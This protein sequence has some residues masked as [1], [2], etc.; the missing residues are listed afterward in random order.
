M[1]LAVAATGPCFSDAPRNSAQR[2]GGR[3]QFCPLSEVP[4]EP[5]YVQLTLFVSHI[6]ALLLYDHHVSRDGGDTSGCT[7]L[8][9]PAGIRCF[10]DHH[11]T[12]V[13]GLPSFVR[14]CRP[15]EPTP[16]LAWVPPRCE[17]LST[18]LAQTEMNAP[19]AAKSVPPHSIAGIYSSGIKP[20]MRKTLQMVL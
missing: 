9:T 3:D 18:D 6:S 12:P 4:Q 14:A 7:T 2:R 5:K 8:E 1:W 17:K 16:G 20:H 15:S 19:F 10:V 13:S 11:W